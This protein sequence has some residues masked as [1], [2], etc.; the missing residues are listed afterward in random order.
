VAYGERHNVDNRTAAN[1]LALDR[2]VSAIKLRGI[3]A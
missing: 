1:M 3:Y 2:V